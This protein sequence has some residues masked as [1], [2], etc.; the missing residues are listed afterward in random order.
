MADN[1]KG[2]RVRMERTLAKELVALKN[3]GKNIR[4]RA[5]MEAVALL[6]KREG[7][8]VVLGVGKSGMVGQKMV[9]TFTSLGHVA[10]FLHPVEA[11]HGDTGIVEAG[12]VLVALSF[13]G[14]SAEVVKITRYLKLN[15]SVPCI[16]V[17]GDGASTLAR[18]SDVSIALSVPDEGCPIGLAPMASA[19][20]TL[21][22]GDLLASALTSPRT[23]NKRHFAKFHPGGSLG[24]D[25]R[26]V[27]EIVK[28]RGALPLVAH[29]APL[30]QAL[31]VMTEDGQGVVGVCAPSGALVGIITDGDVRRFVLAHGSVEAKRAKDAMTKSPKT[32]RL[33]ETARDALLRMEQDRITSLFV[34]EGTGGRP[35]GMIHLH[36]LVGFI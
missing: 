4:S 29:H 1:G 15:F 21:A 28:E 31:K 5:F 20:A 7:K 16:A 9:A 13:S 12:D 34:V 19:L 6:R 26:S 18:L 17:T 8:I 2:A 36:D 27:R 14:E 25:A 24:L 33:D 30:S 11:L 35:V 3:L 22:V 23:F 10:V 32:A